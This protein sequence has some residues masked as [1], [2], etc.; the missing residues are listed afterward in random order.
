LE[1]LTLAIFLSAE[2][3]FFGVAVLTAVQTPLFWGELWSIALR[4]LEF[5]PFKRAGAFAFF[6]DTSR[7]LRTNWLKVGICFLLSKIFYVEQGHIIITS[8]TA[9]HSIIGNKQKKRAFLPVL[10]QKNH[11]KTRK[12]PL[13]GN[14]ESYHKQRCFVN[15]FIRLSCG[16]SMFYPVLPAVIRRQPPVG[17]N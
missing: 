8:L 10:R 15:V 7:P 12:T 5:Q 16:F 4:F 17:L 9:K 6:S 3:G 14:L 11:V 1:S 2:F 13:L